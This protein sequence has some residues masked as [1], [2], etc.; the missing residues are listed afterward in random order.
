MVVI[1][2][3]RS[4]GQFETDKGSAVRALRLLLHFGSFMTKGPSGRS[5]FSPERG[6]SGAATLAYT[7]HWYGV[8]VPHGD[9]W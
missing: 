3:S 2:V 7:G 9:C 5:W 8:L 1:S 4:S 6:P